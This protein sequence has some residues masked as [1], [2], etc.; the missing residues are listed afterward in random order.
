MHW[1][2]V[3]LALVLLLI[4]LHVYLGKL[5]LDFK[6]DRNSHGHVFYRWINEVPVLFLIG[7]YYSYDCEAYS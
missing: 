1:F 5:L 7:Y 2:Q 4:V 6:Y 3:K